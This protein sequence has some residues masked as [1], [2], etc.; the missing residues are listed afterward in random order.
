MFG[1]SLPVAIML[2]V[3]RYELSVWYGVPSGPFDANDTPA[4][5]D[6]SQDG[7]WAALP[8][9]QDG[10]DVTP[11]N[12]DYQDHQATAL[13]DVFFMHPTTHLRP[14]GWN[15]ALGDPIANWI[16]D[17]HVLPGQASVFNAVAR[18]YAPRYRQMNLHTPMGADAEESL[19]LAY[20]DIR[21][22]FEHYLKHWN[23][24]RPIIL[25][26]HSQGSKHGLRLLVEYFD[27]QPL[28]ERLV[29]AYLIG[30]RGRQGSTGIPTCQARTDTACIIGWRSF[31]VGGPGDYQRYDPQK[32]LIGCINPLN[33]STE[34]G[35]Q[36][37]SE[38]LGSLPLA[39]LGGIASTDRGSVG[40]ECKGGT[41]WVSEPT[42]IGYTVGL[43][44]GRN[45]HTYDYHLFYN[46]IRTNAIERV[47]A[48]LANN[49][50]PL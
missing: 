3:F 27:G 16:T 5:P 30:T 14:Y 31:G 34:N 6:Y 7:S 49:G 8:A 38:N 4:P 13:V 24:G 11:S 18:I 47:D 43:W 1:L 26:G 21:A 20:Q 28:K 36:P 9:R 40:A 10:S 46:N 29:A 25:A 42:G 37:A 35:L 23:D 33:W 12:E 17:E 15:A 48:F 32:H 39:L 22:A 41:L 45:Y 44:P 2:F 50:P 19:N